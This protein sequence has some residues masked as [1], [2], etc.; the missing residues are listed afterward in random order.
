MPARIELDGGIDEVLE[1]G[2]RDDLIEAVIHLPAGQA[3]QH[4]VYVD[5]LPA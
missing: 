3:E 1:L 5:V 2:E 4:A